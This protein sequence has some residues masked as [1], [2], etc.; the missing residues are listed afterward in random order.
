MMVDTILETFNRHGV[1][2]LLIG[3][4]NFMLRHDPVLTYDVDVWIADTPENRARCEA[5]LAALEG[6]WGPTEQDWGP[7]TKLPAGWL[8]RQ[9]VFSLTTEAGAVDVFRAV[10][11]LGDW[12]V[13][14]AHGVA[15]RTAA[16]TKYRGLSDED[17]LRCQEAIVEDEQKPERIR[18]LRQALK[19]K[20]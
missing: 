7:V 14:A 13:C 3:G 11:G 4:M 20:T 1:Q 12:A 19:K 16:G 8:A 17:M 5:A 15:E 10:S 9:P 18:R 2:Y 6:A